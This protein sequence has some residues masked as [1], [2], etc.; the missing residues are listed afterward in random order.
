[1]PSRRIIRAITWLVFIIVVGTPLF[2]WKWS[3]FPYTIPKI[4]FFEAAVELCFALWLTLAMAD[5]RYR[6]RMTALTW[7]V[8]GYLGILTITAFTGVDAWRSFFS[9]LE[10]GFGILAYYH[11]A[12]LALV[13]STLHAEIPWK[14]IWYA[15]FGVSL[16]TVG[17]AAIQLKFPDLLLANDSAAGRPGAT[18]GN[19]TFLAGYLL[20]NIF[21]AG[22]YIL[23][24]TEKNQRPRG[25]ESFFLWATTIVGVLGV[26]ITETRG[27][28]LGLFAGAFTLVVLFA[29]RPPPGSSRFFSKRSFY[30]LLVV[31]LVM[32]GGG[33]WLTRGN[34]IWSHVPGIDR[35]KD[36]TISG[37]NSDLGPRIIA[38]N[39]AWNGFLE[40]PLT[41]WGFENF[42]VIFN[43]YY[44]PKVL[45]YGYAESNFDK[46]HSIAFE[47]L[48][49]GGIFL[50]L[51]YLGVL[52][53]LI[54]ESWKLK[55]RLI[56]QCVLAAVLA[57]IV[58]SMV[59]F[60]TIGPAM[61]LYLVMGWTEGQKNTSSVPNSNDRGGNAQ[62]FRGVI[63][64][65]KVAITVAAALIIAYAINGTAMATGYLSWQGHE[66]LQILN[67]MPAGLAAFRS[68]VT[69]WNVYQWD[70]VR[71][72]SNTIAQAY[73][74]NK[75]VP[76]GEV[77]NAIMLT[78]QVAIAHPSDAYNHYLLTNV[79]NL[80][81]DIDP[82]NYL[83]EAEKQAQIAFE[84]SPGRQEIY[85]YLAKTKSLEGDDAGALAIAKQA[86]DLDPKVADS[87]FYYG[88]LAF[89]DGKNDIGY[90]EVETAIGMGRQWRNFYEPRVAGDY[91]ADSGHISQAIDLYRAALSLEPKD[92]E[93]EIKLGAAYYLDDNKTLAKQYLSDAAS[94]FDFTKSPVYLQYKPILDA[95]GIR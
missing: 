94:R 45:E 5:R 15:S 36:L 26:F 77:K 80:A 70:F 7:A 2:Y 75:S 93:S 95:L 8:V 10:R 59:I 21:L 35:L 30:I 24:Q 1:M 37:A 85:F 25:K 68:S 22:Y 41:G 17:I 4:A 67:D 6:P 3:L 79:Y 54:Y 53:A 32:G 83:A 57:Y 42:N 47:E 78:N 46:P 13:V 23:G 55:D 16:F 82:K 12:A 69:T 66:N 60:D 76:Q 65:S 31:I 52:A 84:L 73:F 34:V 19:P 64:K 28:I 14:K 48:D 92:L 90:T 40:R 51:A 61:M 88:M 72:Y 44:D 58:R 18:F 86:L 20:F 11:L 43:K 29:F 62:G 39:A 74:Y 50:L 89:A 81:Y 27:D 33:I 71:D 9:D 87:H 38:L 91:F 56:G 49:A 63:D